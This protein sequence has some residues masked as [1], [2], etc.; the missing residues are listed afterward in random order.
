MVRSVDTGDLAPGASSQAMTI[1]GGQYHRTIHAVMV[2]A[3]TRTPPRP[4]VHRRVLRLSAWLRSN[5][6][7]SA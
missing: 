2:G 1:G 6:R 5:P 7:A 4:G 3:S